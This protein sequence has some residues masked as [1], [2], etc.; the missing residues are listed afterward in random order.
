MV[1]IDQIKQLRE[2]T[3]VSISEVKKALE[4]SK[5][6]AEKAK[7]LLRMWGK[8]VAGKKASREMEIEANAGWVATHKVH[9]S[10]KDYNRKPKHRNRTDF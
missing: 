3:G 9:K 1:T 7:E 4:A 2:E 8:A 5:G 6:N 10:Q